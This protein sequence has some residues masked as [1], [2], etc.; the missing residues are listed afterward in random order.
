MLALILTLVATPRPQADLIRVRGNGFEYATSP[1]TGAAAWANLRTGKRLNLGGS[2]E[3]ELEVG[4]EPKAAVK[5]ELIPGAPPRLEADG[6]HAFLFFKSRD[7]ALSVEERLATDPSDS[8]LRKELFVTNSGAGP[9]RL[10]NVVL[11]RFPVRGVKPEGGE[12]GFP[13]YLDNQF[14]VSVAHP[15]GFAHVESG[16]VVLRQYPGKW[17]GPGQTIASMEAVYGVAGRGGAKTFFVDYVRSR[18]ARVVYHH[19]H[20]YSVLESFGGQPDGDY[21]RNFSIGV[22]ESYLLRHL[23][24]V[25]Q[26]EAA[27]GFK[28]DFYGME[29]WHDRAGDLKTFNRKNFPNGFDS[30]R[31][32][33]LGLGMKPALWID[34]GRLPY[35][36]I[37]QNPA[38]RRC[39]NVR[40]GVG[41]LCRASEPLARMYKDA[42]LYQ[43]SHN[44]VGL[45]KFDNLESVCNN[46]A[47]DHL[48]GPLYSTEAIYD[49]IIDFFRTLRSANPY[50]FIELYWGYHSPWW[51]LYGD[52]CFDTG[53]SIEAASPAQFPAPYARD[54]VTQRLDQA[55]RTVS[56]T[57]WL[58]KDTLGVWLSDWAWNSGIGSARWQ[59]GVIM[60][61]ARGNL[62]LQLWT[63]AD[64]LTPPE[65][66]QLA[67]FGRLLE[68]DAACFANPAPILGNPDR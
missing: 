8:V 57:P 25:A 16:S 55:Q 51:L 32:R 6:A 66:A 62:L 34:S 58:G 50:L 47:H 24:D 43:M 31:D 44:K 41:H 59:E 54:S 60:D 39:F 1:S 61:M 18:M 19:D 13:L 64:W 37:D 35:W 33:I 38:V 5:V 36:T 9:V 20:A 63:D 68:S 30:V 26:G 67:T 23:D 15:A 40:D 29:F 27:T 46:P 4:A 42:Y 28:F 65:R 22:S 2:P 56:D 7:G 53:G 11:G 3:V 21:K 48:P 45:V 52:T 17:L 49:S 14:F 10:L 12:R